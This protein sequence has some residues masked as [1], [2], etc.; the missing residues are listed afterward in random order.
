MR[1]FLF[2][3]AN[4]VGDT[5]LSLDSLVDNLLLYDEC[6][7]LI[8]KEGLSRGVLSHTEY[9]LNQNNID[10]DYINKYEFFSMCD[11]ENDSF[12]IHYYKN[13]I[14]KHD[15]MSYVEYISKKGL[16]EYIDIINIII[17]EYGADRIDI[18]PHSEPR[19]GLVDFS[20]YSRETPDD[21]SIVVNIDSERALNFSVGSWAKIIEKLK[22]DRVTVFTFDKSV[23]IDGVDVIY[24]DND[25][26]NIS[27]VIQSAK[28]FLTPNTG[29]V[30][31]ANKIGLP[32]VV[33]ITNLESVD[34]EYEFYNH[35]EHRKIVFTNSIYSEYC[36]K[37]R[38]QN[39]ELSAD[40]IDT[41]AGL[42]NNINYERVDFHR[43]GVA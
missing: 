25:I 14:K 29:I 10:F 15:V 39:I 4:T 28:V 9:A 42:I 16:K 7:V 19:I 11:I 22:Y 13:H 5:I 3:D 43:E 38:R 40:E 34:G 26:Y 12:Y 31:L 1:V 21:N 41:V 23:N 36:D 18:T 27:S 2:I 8:F 20:E 33:S 30:H 17:A 37:I 35:K 6:K 32:C 24:M